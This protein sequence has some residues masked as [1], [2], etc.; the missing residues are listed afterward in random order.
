VRIIDASQEKSQKENPLRRE[1]GER[2]EVQ[3]SGFSA[4]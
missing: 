2:E 1:D 4:R 3:S